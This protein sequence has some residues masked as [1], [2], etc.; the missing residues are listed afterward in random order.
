[1]RITG[2]VRDGE[3]FEVIAKPTAMAQSTFCAISS[4]ELSVTRRLSVLFGADHAS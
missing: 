4:G 2:D 3:E 1:M